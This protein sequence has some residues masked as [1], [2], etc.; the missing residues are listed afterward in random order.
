MEG[1]SSLML[2]EALDYVARHPENFPEKPG[3]EWAVEFL[4]ELTESKGEAA[5]NEKLEAENRSPPRAN[6]A[7]T[8]DN[9]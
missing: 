1:I 5:P 8:F 9:A 4:R 6:G 3:P 7:E 2:I